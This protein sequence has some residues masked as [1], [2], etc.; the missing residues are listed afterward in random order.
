MSAQGVTITQIYSN[1]GPNVSEP[2]LYAV[3][4][5]QPY[6]V[7][8]YEEGSVGFVGQGDLKSPIAGDVALPYLDASDNTPENLFAKIVSGDDVWYSSDSDFAI[9]MSGTSIY[10]NSVTNWLATSYNG[11]SVNLFNVYSVAAPLWTSQNAARMNIVDNSAVKVGDFLFWSANSYKVKVTQVMSD[12]TDVK[13]NNSAGTINASDGTVTAYRNLS[14]AELFVR[15]KAAIDG[16]D[17]MFA[18]ASIDDLYDKFGPG[19]IYPE[20]KLGYG[21]LKA[22]SAAGV[23]VKGWATRGETSANYTE[24]FDDIK[25]KKDMYF[26]VPLTFDAT[27]HSNLYS[28]VGTYAEPAKKHEMRAYI[29]RKIGILFNTQNIGGSATKTFAVPAAIASDLNIGDRVLINNGYG[30]KPAGTKEGWVSGIVGTSVTLSTTV[31]AYQGLTIVPATIDLEVI[32]AE[33]L[34]KGFNNKR[35]TLIGPGYFEDNNHVVEGY[36]AAAAYAGWRSGTVVHYSSTFEPIIGFT[37]IPRAFYFDDD[38]FRTLSDAGWLIYK[39]D[40]PSQTPYALRQMTT[41]YSVLETA[42]ESLVIS[43]DDIAKWLRKNL[44]PYLSRGIDNRISQNASDPVT[45]RYLKKIQKVVNIA[46][47]KYVD[48]STIFAGIEIK[49]LKPNPSIKDRTD[50]VVEVSFYYPNNTIHV[51]LVQV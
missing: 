25:K 15:Y 13:V 2:S 28:L 43:F 5:G 26:I 46:K 24:A 32:D 11:V 17:G 45:K 10:I 42:E 9:A 8:T 50:L 14:G 3:I 34:S 41:G 7:V 16:F 37:G 47:V 12:G 6:R 39:Q 19:Y 20:S 33:T 48:D 44:E 36:Y 35:V 49:E 40:T 27:V 30:A 22:Y 29:S 51:E 21:L 23:K 31:N 4:I 1:P 38:Q 18:V